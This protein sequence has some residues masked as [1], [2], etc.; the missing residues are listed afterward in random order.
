VAIAGI[1]WWHTPGYSGLGRNVPIY[2]I[3]RGDR[4]TRLLSAANYVLLAPKAEPPPPP[5]EQ[6][7]AFARPVQ[8]IYKRPGGCTPD[9]SAQVVRP[10]GIPG[11]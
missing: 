6:W 10:E 1:R 11:V 5:Y 7:R 9:P 2:E 8:Y 3:G 4:S